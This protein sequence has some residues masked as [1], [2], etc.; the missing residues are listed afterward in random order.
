MHSLQ[1]A[2]ASSLSTL[3]LSLHKTDVNFNLR[4]YLVVKEGLSLKDLTATCYITFVM[5]TSCTGC[6]YY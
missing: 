4:R 6:L 5:R 3:M 2:F 1:T